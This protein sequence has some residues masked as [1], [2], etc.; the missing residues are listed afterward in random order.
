MYGQVLEMLWKF[1]LMSDEQIAK[2]LKSFWEV[3]DPLTAPSQ[4]IALS[5]VKTVTLPLFFSVA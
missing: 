3:P 1:Y 4:E 5:L 2:T